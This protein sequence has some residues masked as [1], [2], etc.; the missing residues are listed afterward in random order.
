MIVL[1]RLCI[2]L[3]VLFERHIGDLLGELAHFTIS[4]LFSHYLSKKGRCL[5]DVSE[6]D[7]CGLGLAL[8]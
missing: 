4:L 7:G 3:E 5:R 6:V 2:V 1:F 8:K